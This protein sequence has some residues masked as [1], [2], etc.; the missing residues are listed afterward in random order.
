MKLLILSA[1]AALA[2]LAS[3]AIAAPLHAVEVRFDKSELADS[4]KAYKKLVKAA[5]NECVTPGRKPLMQKVSENRCYRELI[6]ELVE[7][8]GIDGVAAL[9]A[10]AQ[11]P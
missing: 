8:V 2:T 11:K 5:R 10:T 6:T 4:A 9:H 3:P 1:A 7:K